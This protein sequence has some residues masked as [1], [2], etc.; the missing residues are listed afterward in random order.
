MLLI[1]IRKRI[2]LEFVGRMRKMY[3]DP[4]LYRNPEINSE[5]GLYLDDLYEEFIVYSPISYLALTLLM[6]ISNFSH[7]SSS[8]EIMVTPILYTNITRYILLLRS[9]TFWNL[10]RH[11]NGRHF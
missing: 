11:R 8:I 2:G 6:T 5:N 4:V 9:Y 3:P 7:L 1:I 10:P